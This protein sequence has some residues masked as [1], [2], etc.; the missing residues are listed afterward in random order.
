MEKGS[1]S[2]SIVAGPNGSGKTTFSR[3]ILN[4]DDSI[5]TFLNPDLI[6]AGISPSDHEQA[7]FQAGRVLLTEIRERMESGESFG[8]ES[9]LSG[10][11]YLSLLTKA[12]AAGYSITIH[13]VFVKSTELSLSRIRQRVQEGGHDIPRAAVLRRRKRCFENFWNL[14]RPLSDDWYLFDNSGKL[15]RLVVSRGDYEN[16]DTTKKNDFAKAFLKGKVHDKKRARS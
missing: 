16:W 12:K 14:Y 8:F 1:R 9:T 3:S 7:S 11:T 5:P 4:L 10:K 15:P 13:F 6:A 2:L